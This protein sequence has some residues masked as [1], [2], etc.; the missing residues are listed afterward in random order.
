MKDLTS[1]GVLPA[2][3]DLDNAKE[4]TE[5]MMDHALH[6]FLMGKVAATVNELKSAKAIVDE[7]VDVA[8]QRLN[9]GKDLLVQR[10]KL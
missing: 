10:S 3:H 8:A 7:I 2:H 6:P 4:L 9:V 1:R 5:E